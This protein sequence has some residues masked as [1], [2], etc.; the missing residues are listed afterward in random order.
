MRVNAPD[1]TARFAGLT[2]RDIC[3]LLS[4][5]PLVHQ[6]AIEHSIME[7]AIA[8]SLTPEGTPT[9]DDIEEDLFPPPPRDTERSAPWTVGGGSVQWILDELKLSSLYA[10]TF[11]EY[12]IVS[13]QQ[14]T[15][16]GREGLQERL[17]TLGVT[18]D[19]RNKIERLAFS[20]RPCGA[21]PPSPTT[22]TASAGRATTAASRP[23]ENGARKPP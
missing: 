9:A 21:S 7:S 8:K 2:V 14:L 17:K 22:S 20:P 1:W 13:A 5:L 23:R 6:A 16:H 12:C 19:H 4:S 11:D 18:R 3:E 10:P 15:L